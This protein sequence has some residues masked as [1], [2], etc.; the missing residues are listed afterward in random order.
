MKE[1]YHRVGVR[2][3]N[4]LDIHRE[5]LLYFRSPFN[6]WAEWYQIFFKNLKRP[7]MTEKPT[8]EE[9]EKR[10][11]QLERAQ[12]VH[13]QLEI[14]T[15]ITERK[16]M[17]EALRESEKDLRKS[18]QIAHLGSWRLDVATNQVT[19]TEEL[20][21]MYGFDPELP[22][23]PYNEHMKLFSPESWEKLSA[24]LAK[25]RETGI[26]YELELETVKKDGSHGWIWV[27]GEAI[28]DSNDNITGLW[29]AAQEI[30]ARKHSEQALQESEAFIKAVMDN[31]PIG[32][33]VNSIDPLVKF[34]YMN[35]NFP[36]IYR[37]TREAL[38]V[39]DNFWNAVYEDPAFREKISRRVLEDLASGDPERTHWEYIP[40]TRKGEKTSFISARNKSV[41]GKPLMISTVWDV[42]ARKEAEDQNT[43][44]KTIADNA[45]YGKAIA[46]LQGN[47]VYVNR[48]F[49]NIHG[50]NPGEL[51]GHH[52]SILHTREQMEE[53]KLAIASLM[54]K[55]HFNPRKSWHLHRNTTQFPMLMSGILVKDENGTPQCIASSAI[56]ITE[57]HRAEQKYQT[58]FREMLNGFALHEIICNESGEPVDYR[59][60]AVNPAFEKMT[61]LKAQEITGR[62]VLE[63]IPE[64]E[65]YWID[66]YGKVALT[67]EPAFFENYSSDLKK[68]FEVTAFRPASNQFACIFQDI[69]ERK[70]AEEERVKLQSQLNQ[71]QKMESVGR[72]AGGVAHDFNNM[73][74]VILGHTELALEE[75]DE[76]HG[77]FSDL[78]EIQTAAQ[79]SAN[80]TKQLLTFA[81]KQI[82]APRILDLNHTIES[83]LNMLHRLIGEDID[84]VWKPA[85]DLWPVKMDPSQVDQILANLCV[86]ARDAIADVGRLTIETCKQTFNGDYC[87]EHQGFVPGDFVMLALSDNGC[88]MDKE[89]LENLFEPFFTTKDVGKGTGLGLATVY[90]IVK[91]NKGFI[92]VYSEPG[93]GTTFKIYL[94]RFT[95]ADKEVTLVPEEKKASGGDETILLVEDEPSILKMT[96]MMLERKGYTVLSAGTPAEALEIARE[97]GDK[98]D[99]LITDVIMPGMNGRDLAE[100]LI[101]LYPNI[102]FLFMSGY[103]AN[104]IAH[105][106]ILEQGV[107]FIQ[108]PFS[109]K[110]L[111]DK[112]RKV[113]DI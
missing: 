40:I 15:H 107:P 76:N 44:F 89:T 68:H 22:P 47:L 96:R 67:G 63:I 75:A 43:I 41:P 66:T 81:R 94:P 65:P 71:A 33:A 92:N 69:T 10:I 109:M 88:G 64:T 110:D 98:I 18:Q 30:T 91:Q 74:G 77:L 100:K 90:G 52:L 59:F 51:I 48:F 3:N 4:L 62:T 112:L 86:N 61:G 14:V 93:K 16:R 35:D 85:G 95:E 99:L 34:N 28:R 36:A 101:S 105:Q 83:M 24:S 111:A 58:L 7:H 39:P 6:V 13:E 82:I 102:K 49:A 78:K 106:G 12:S 1:K 2:V 60:L 21:K 103:S 25:T 57:S 20:Y 104:V 32:V 84:L 108:K 54:K 113:L 80:L 53:E 29:G 42:T 45:V 26:P 79:R 55:G 17:E 50:Y 31:L 5:R 87:S 37:T 97:H 70:Q 9:L 72:L 11:Q 38:A 73:L 19:W 46:D 27:R 23:P 56:D 8:Y